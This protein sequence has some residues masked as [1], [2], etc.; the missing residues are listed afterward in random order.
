LLLSFSLSRAQVISSEIYE[1]EEDLEEGLLT[2][3]ITLDEYLELLDLIFSPVNLST[4]ESSRLL[5]VPDLSI[6]EID[7]SPIENYSL[8]FQDKTSVFT[9][10]EIGKEKRW[11]SEF[12]WQIKETFQE[13]EQ[14]QNFFRFRI[15][16]QNRFSLNWEGEQNGENNFLFRRRSLEI[17]NLLY[18]DKIILGT[19][20]KKMG[21]GLNLGYHPYFNYGSDSVFDFKDSFLNP[22]K[23]RYNGIYLE[24]KLNDF[25]AE[26][27]FSKNKFREM[28]NDLYAL[29]FSFNRKSFKSGLLFSKGE[30]SD[31]KTK[32]KY[33]DDCLSFYFDL[34]GKSTKLSSEYAT[35]L[36]G[37]WGGAIN[38]WS[39]GRSYW[40]DVAGWWYSK[41]FIHPYGNGISNPDYETVYL[42]EDLSFRDRQREER[43]MFFKSKY[44]LISKGFLDFAYT[45]WRKNEEEDKKIKTKF[46]GGYSLS[47]N[48]LSQFHILLSDDI[49]EKGTDYFV[50]SW[51]SK[52]SFEKK[53]HFR[54]R[55]NYRVKRLA[56]GQKRYGDIQLKFQT[57]RF[58]PFDF[59]FWLKYNDPDFSVSKDIYWDFY[60]QEKIEV[61]ENYSLSFGYWAKF[62]QDE[63]RLDTKGFKARLEMKW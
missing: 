11:E 60:W 40:I 3:E 49:E 48:I 25:Q 1:T 57:R 59:T 54:S 43:G 9:R 20:D 14:L 2:G 30:F 8:L 38:L 46:G 50:Y 13:D 52:F 51:D 55:A 24:S 31:A 5:F 12:I 44:Q 28:E 37:E 6:V 34:G 15:K 35:L 26:F 33:K 63:N 62:Y 19:F 22:L 36:N 56:F 4:E 18:L 32:G 10:S 45:E 7:S 61:L 42:L 17:S 16:N 23:G 58:S 29:D 47:E 39:K 53:S 27:L 21:L 41:D